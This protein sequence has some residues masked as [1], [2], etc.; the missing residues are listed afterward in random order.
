MDVPL[1]ETCATDN[2]SDA[3]L[4]WVPA[5]MGSK[6]E[7]LCLDPPRIMA[8]HFFANQHRDGLHKWIKLMCKLAQEYAGR[9]MFGVRDIKSIGHLS[10]NLNAN[11]FGSYRPGMPPLIFAEDKKHHVYQMNSLVSHRNLKK[12]CEK[13]LQQQLFQAV[14]LA[15][16]IELDAPPQNYFDV[17]DQMDGDYL[18]IV[19]DPACYN[20]PIQLKM[21]RKLARLLAN[22]AVH[23]VIIN[24]AHNHLGVVFHK[25]LQDV[26]CHGVKIV[27]S[28]RVNGYNFK[29]HPRLHS[30]RGYLRYIAQGRQ[31]ELIDYDAN[32]ESRAAEQALP[33]IQCLFAVESN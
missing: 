33:Y 7:K 26:N 10:D 21:L 4:I 16:T 20:W 15:P 17:E 12:F 23:V 29:I 13:L 14:V 22:E 5:G 18:V 19:Y 8:F 11:D 32:G 9:I 27:S 28:P 3:W 25:V 6:G 1:V 31:P 2:N 24:R 30:T